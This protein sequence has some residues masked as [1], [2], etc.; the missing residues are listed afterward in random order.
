[1]SDGNIP[2]KIVQINILFVSCL[3][4]S[5]DKYWAVVTYAV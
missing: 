1:M 5:L 4:N 3:N 2:Y